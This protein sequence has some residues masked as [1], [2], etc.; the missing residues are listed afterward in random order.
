MQLRLSAPV[1]YLCA[2][3]CKKIANS[4][5]VGLEPSLEIIYNARNTPAAGVIIIL[6]PNV[7]SL[8]KFSRADSGNGC[9]RIPFAL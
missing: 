3:H 7:K 8:R 9:T 1:L 5:L 4:T 6:A 2:L